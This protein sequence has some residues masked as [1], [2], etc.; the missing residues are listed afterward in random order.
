MVYP[1]RNEGHNLETIMEGKLDNILS[2]HR[3][4]DIDA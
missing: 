3:L 4:A 2:D 1:E